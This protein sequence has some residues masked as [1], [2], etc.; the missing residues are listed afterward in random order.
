MV[1]KRNK[2]SRPARVTPQELV[3]NLH[4]ATA[5]IDRAFEEEVR[6]PVARPAHRRT[7]QAAAPGRRVSK[8]KGA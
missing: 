1:M 8:R 3:E 2:S 6:W 4:R 5:E 7:P